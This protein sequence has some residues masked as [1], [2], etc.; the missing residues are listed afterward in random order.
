MKVRREGTPAALVMMGIGLLGALIQMDQRVA[1]ERTL[2]KVALVLDYDEVARLA[3]VSGT[4]LS[5]VLRCVR[6]TVSHVA[7]PEQTWADLQAAGSLATWNASLVPHGYVPAGYTVLSVAN[8][9]KAQ[10]ITAALRAKGIVVQAP[11][12]ADGSEIMLVPVGRAMLVPTAVLQ[13]VDLGLGYDL[14][15]AE[16][17]KRVGL[18]LVAR[19]RST[20]VT[21]GDAVRQTLQLARQIGA[22]IVIFLGNEVLG[23]PGAIGDTAAA[24][25][26]LRLKFGFVELSPQFGAEQ[27]AR[28]ASDLVVRTHSIS[29]L[30]MRVMRPSEAIE[31]YARAVRERQVRVLYLRLLPT[32]MDGK[33]L[34]ATNLSYLKSVRDAIQAAGFEIGEPEAVPALQVSPTLRALMGIGIAG[35]TVLVL[36]ALGVVWAARWP[37]LL[38]VAVVF[39]AAASGS[40]FS[41]HAL[42]LLGAI[43]AATVGFVALVPPRSNS[44]GAL[45]IAIWYLLA[46]SAATI[47]L[48]S[49]GA[50]LLSDQRHMVGAELFRGVKLSLVIPPLIVLFV[51]AARGTRAY[52]EW[53]TEAG[54]KQEWPALLAGA[55]EAAE[56]VVK[57]WHVVLAL[58]LMAAA[59]L[60]VVRSG[61]EPLFGLA[62]VEIRARAAME[63]LVGVRPRTKE[64]A[65]GHPLALLGLWLLHRGRRRGVWLI[66]TAGSIGQASLANTF[67][68]IH[69][70]YLLSLMRGCLGLACG[71]LIGLALVAL[72]AFMETRL[73]PPARRQISS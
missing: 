23:N 15:V 68:H 70:P 37:V 48:A 54:G 27:L 60:M 69:S 71:L 42:S 34:L 17:V 14:Q 56:H 6:G 20:L 5:E 35:G 44:A 33:D 10:Q 3:A 31:R 11:T 59:A 1:I 51:Q 9:S 49:I 32:A 40:N 29:D 43:T 62:G 12:G 66:L 24:L 41:R 55:R 8:W 67:C 18:A 7:L 58:I 47:V 28:A 45:R 50:A 63:R 16:Q 52:W 39:A 30:E 73:R 21:S 64:F 53:R 38:A 25:R 22:R 4:D 46:I 19:P 2:R 65:V 13:A 57:Y 61:N 72:W 26:Q 36:L